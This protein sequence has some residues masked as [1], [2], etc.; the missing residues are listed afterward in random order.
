MLSARYFDNIFTCTQYR[1]EVTATL[2][3]IANVLPKCRES[4]YG[5]ELLRGSFA[6]WDNV[7]LLI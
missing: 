5:N 7:E 6:S 2:I 1:F 4:L 3:I